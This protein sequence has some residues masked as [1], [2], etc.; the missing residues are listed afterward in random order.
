M[1]SRCRCRQIAQQLGVIGKSRAIEACGWVQAP[2]DAQLGGTGSV[3]FGGAL[4]QAVAA[5][6]VG[7]LLARIAAEG[8]EAA[9]LDAV[10]ADVE[11]SV[12]HVGDRVARQSAAQL[13]GLLAQLG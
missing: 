4:L 1:H 8:A 10:V 2:L 9:V 6:P 11:V 5:V 12:H 13:V 7:T 3:G